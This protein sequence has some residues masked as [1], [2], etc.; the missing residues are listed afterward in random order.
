ML[1]VQPAAAPVQSHCGGSLAS[2]VTHAAGHQACDEPGVVS[3]GAWT[4]EP[5]LVY[6]ARAGEL[7]AIQVRLGR[8]LLRMLA[9][10]RVHRGIL[11]TEASQQLKCPHQGSALANGAV[12]DIEDVGAANSSGCSGTH[13]HEIL[14][15][16]IS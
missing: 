3:V 2:C 16:V 9:R 1:E 6:K 14:F 4:G 8:D 12:A 10:V 11:L 13:S 5:V 15:I 7:F